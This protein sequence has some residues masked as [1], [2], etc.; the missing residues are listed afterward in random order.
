MPIYLNKNLNAVATYQVDAAGNIVGGTGTASDQVQGTSAA[1]TA[2]TG[3]P[4]KVGGVY[5]GASP[6]LA[7]G[8]VGNFQ[9]D[10]FGSLKTALYHQDSNVPLT[11]TTA[12][13]GGSN[14]VFAL[15]TYAACR[16]WN[17]N[18]WDRQRGDLT[19]VWTHAPQNTVS[20]ALSGTIATAGATSTVA[21]VNTA[22]QEVINPSTGTLWASWGTPAVNGAG[23]FQIAPGGSFS[24][25]RTT[26]TLTLLSTAATQPFTV[27]RY[28]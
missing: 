22:R 16:V 24:T 26:G 4:V 19:G 23:S 13:D 8:Q 12:S 7:V 21:F 3:N 9:L 20:T 1:Q 10:S 27:N 5:A 18:T 15:T 2:E 25:D 28:S 14:N 11:T 17:G 6:G